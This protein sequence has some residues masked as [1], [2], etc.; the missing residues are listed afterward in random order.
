MKTLKRI[1]VATFCIGL[2]LVVAGCSGDGKDDKKDDGDK[3][4]S[5]VSATHYCASCGDEAGSDTCCSGDKCD[6][7]GLQKES[8]L[9]CK[10]VQ[11]HCGECGQQKGT[12]KCC[13][14]DAVTCKDCG[15]HKGADLCCNGNLSK[16][17]QLKFCGDC[18]HYAGSGDCC[19]KDAKACRQMRT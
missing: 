7:C 14:E 15:F 1:N 17:D 5:Q 16:G 10:D 6:S 4:T 3:K 18:G 8:A 9:C 12:E 13:A 2:A 11:V 19:S